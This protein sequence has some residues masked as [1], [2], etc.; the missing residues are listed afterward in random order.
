MLVIC[1]L[2]FIFTKNKF[3]KKKKSLLEPGGHKPDL[4]L[5]NLRELPIRGGFINANNPMYNQGWF[6]IMVFVEWAREKS[7]ISKDRGYK[8][9]QRVKA[10]IVSNSSGKKGSGS[11]Y[12]KLKLLPKLSC[13]VKSLGVGQPSQN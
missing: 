9:Y 10:K 11:G 1:I 3:A 12:K 6:N 13:L 7:G 4:E 8:M 2:Y 5:A